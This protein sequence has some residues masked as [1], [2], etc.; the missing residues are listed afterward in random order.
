[1]KS[2]LGYDKSLGVNFRRNTEHELAGGRL[3][4]LA[5][6]GCTVN[7]MVVNSS[8]K[9]DPKFLRC[10]PMKRYTVFNPNESISYRFLTEEICDLA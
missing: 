5:P 1:M 6:S 7:D 9:V 10:R 3:K 4:W 2:S 8:L